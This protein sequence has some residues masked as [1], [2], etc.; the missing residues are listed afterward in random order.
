[1]FFNADFIRDHL[2]PSEPQIIATRCAAKQQAHAERQNAALSEQQVA[3]QVA[4]LRVE[5]VANFGVGPDNGPLGVRQA[6][7]AEA[8][9]VDE[10]T[11]AVVDFLEHCVV[12]V[13]DCKLVPFH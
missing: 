6:D 1:M 3:N 5:P 8:N 12:S 7:T 10:N 2:A 11:E 9:V 4:A 13:S